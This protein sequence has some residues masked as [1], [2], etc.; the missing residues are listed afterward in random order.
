MGLVK[1]GSPLSSAS[2]NANGFNYLLIGVDY[3]NYA[4][5]YSCS[6]GITFAWILTRSTKPSSK[7][8]S[9]C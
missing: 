2:Y 6:G 9:N 7:T 1:K 8:V 3:D 4:S 5:V